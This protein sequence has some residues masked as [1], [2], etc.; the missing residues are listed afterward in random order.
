MIIPDGYA[1]VNL[2]WTWSTSGQTAEVVYGV[3]VDNDALDVFAVASAVADAY[4]AAA[5]ASVQTGAI[6]LT[7][8]LVKFGPNDTGPSTEFAQSVD[9]TLSGNAV[10]PNNSLLITKATLHGGRTGRG[11]MYWP[12]T[13]EGVWDD[14]GHL[15]S[16]AADTFQSKFDDFWTAHVSA[17][18]PMYLLHADSGP[19][20]FAVSVL[21]VRPLIAT[22]RRRLGR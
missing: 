12:G 9:G 5:L 8:I 15:D 1:Q 4:D 6:T 13:Q 14:Y 3:A 11:R 10:T 19:D 2:K 16:G 20:P 22:Q 18:I 21:I 17:D 7:S